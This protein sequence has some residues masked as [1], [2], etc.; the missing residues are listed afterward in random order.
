MISTR[1][2]EDDG[3]TS[4]RDAPRTRLLTLRAVE[5]K[6]TKKRRGRTLRSLC[7]VSAVS[8]SKD[9]STVIL[10]GGFRFTG[11]WANGQKQGFGILEQPAPRLN[12]PT[13]LLLVHGTHVA[14][15]PR[16]EAA[17]RATSWMTSRTVRGGWPMSPVT[18]MRASGWM[19]EQKVSAPSRV[20]MGAPTRAS[21]S[22]TCSMA[23]GLKPGRMA[24]DPWKRV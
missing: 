16:T 24:P 21:G 22:T 1:A 4:S 6:G 13:C 15:F 3:G 12:V 23:T 18:S 17:L 8:S 9:G 11:T 2:M 19:S 14:M 10:E 7:T 20:R 5:R